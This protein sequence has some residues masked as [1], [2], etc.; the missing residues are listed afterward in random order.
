[1]DA[2]AAVMRR[3]N[4]LRGE[5][6]GSDIELEQRRKELVEGQSENTRWPKPKRTRSAR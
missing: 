6:M 1:M 5:Q 3:Q 2:K 4:E